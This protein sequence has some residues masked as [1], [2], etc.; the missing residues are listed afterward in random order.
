M[1][2][3]V[4][5]QNKIAREN[6]PT[7]ES[8]KMRR[9]ALMKTVRGVWWSVFTLLIYSIAKYIHYKVNFIYNL[10]VF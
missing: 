6:G 10:F 1:N 2:Q 4:E 7:F 3:S 9:A 8:E 5:D